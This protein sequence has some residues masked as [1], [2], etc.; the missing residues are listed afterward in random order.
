MTITRLFLCATFVTCPLWAGVAAAHPEVGGAPA[1]TSTVAAP[2][3]TTARK[4]ASQANTKTSHVDANATPAPK[5]GKTKPTPA[6]STTDTYHL[7]HRPHQLDSY[8]NAL[9][10]PPAA[11]ER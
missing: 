6:P 7:S 10:P 5:A 8:Q 11:N 3:T 2:A 4:P 9:T 1:S